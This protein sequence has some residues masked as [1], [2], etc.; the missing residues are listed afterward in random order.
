MTVFRVTKRLIQLSLLGFII[1]VGLYLFFFPHSKLLLKRVLYPE[2]YDARLGNFTL[3]LVSPSKPFYIEGSKIDFKVKANGRKPEK[4]NLLLRQNSERLIELQW[5]ETEGLFEAT[6]DGMVGDI[7]FNLQSEQVLSQE[8][9]LDYRSKPKLEKFNV[10][11]H[12]PEYTGLEPKV[13]RA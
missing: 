6:L 11:Y 12:F 2:P 3:E 13:Q 5:N 7:W 9:H 8:H 1:Y 10:V 4:V